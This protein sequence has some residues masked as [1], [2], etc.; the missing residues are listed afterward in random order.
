MAKRK[1]PKVATTTAKYQRSGVAV[2][3]ELRPED[4]ER[5]ERVASVK[6]LSKASYARMAV[7]AQ[8]K[9]DEAEE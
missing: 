4:I 6:G 5:L 8:I 3:L 2:R 1:A 7:L 9:K